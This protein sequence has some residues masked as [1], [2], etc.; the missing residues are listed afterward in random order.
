MRQGII[1]WAALGL[2]LGAAPAGAE[3]AWEGY[4]DYAYV[5]SSADSEALD[6]RLREYGQEAGLDLQRFI[7]ERL[8]V[9]LSSSVAFC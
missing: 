7:T 4:L 8:P 5:Y 3:D 2:L 9:A 6:Q 1:A